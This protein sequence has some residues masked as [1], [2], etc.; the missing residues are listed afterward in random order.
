MLD[1]ELLHAA[2][3]RLKKSP[4]TRQ[5]DKTLRELVNAPDLF[6]IEYRDRFEGIR[7]HTQPPPPPNRPW[8]QQ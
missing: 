8:N 6:V 7:A 3:K 4:I 2:L 1:R 5:Q